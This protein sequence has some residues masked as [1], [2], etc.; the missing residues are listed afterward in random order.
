MKKIIRQILDDLKP[1]VQ[2]TGDIQAIV[3]KQYEPPAT[4]GHTEHHHNEAQIHV[5]ESQPNAP[6]LETLHLDAKVQPPLEQDLNNQT[7]STDAAQR[8]RQLDF[9]AQK[10]EERQIG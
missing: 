2:P 5:T 1:A 9:Q 6:I 7:P 4:V 10:N 8:V 3:P